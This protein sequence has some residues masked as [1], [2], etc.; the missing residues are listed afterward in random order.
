MMKLF[1]EFS[2]IDK[3][4]WQQQ[5]EKDL[6]G[7]PY[8]DLVWS[9][10][11]DIALQPY[12]TRQ[13]MTAAGNIAKKSNNDWQICETIVVSNP[14]KA[15][16]AALAALMGGANALRIELDYDFDLS[17]L[18]IVLKDIMLSYVAIHFVYVA[19]NMSQAQDLLERYYRI[20][21]A[22]DADCQHLEGSMQFSSNLF[23]DIKGLS[24]LVRYS[25]SHLPKFRSV[26]INAEVYYENHDGTVNELSQT[27][28]MA[29]RVLAQLLTDGVEKAAAAQA[30]HV[31]MSFGMSYFVQ[32]AKV[33]AFRIL[34][35]NVLKSYDID[36][37]IMSHI[38]AKISENVY[39]DSDANT[40]KI[41]MTT[42]AMSAVMAGVDSLTVRAT[43]DESQVFATRIARNVQ[44]ILKMESYLDR[45]ADPAAGSYYI[46][47]LTN[48]LATQVWQ[49][50][51]F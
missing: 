41:R 31:S 28:D 17:D 39:R 25:N 10:G 23:G 36:S 46:E 26:G 16:L 2:G 11:E 27:L 1:D 32:I 3:A 45:V 29:H 22:Q 12:Y 38:D 9:I 8:Q 15:N 51:E 33:R 47:T 43:S 7:K 49:K 4:I 35:A 13:E 30:I 40:N 20:A 44:H 42:V 21:N 14:Q 6:K 24:S 18:K 37:N 5:V 50:I 34:W 19:P 48:E